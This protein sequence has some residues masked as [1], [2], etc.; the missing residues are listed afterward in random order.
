MAQAVPRSSPLHAAA[1]ER[2]DGPKGNVIATA[3]IAGIQA[4]KRTA[5]LIPLFHPLPL[6][7]V[8]VAIKVGG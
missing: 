3:H 5:E 4:A 8:D 2:G 6:S 7:Y 1:V